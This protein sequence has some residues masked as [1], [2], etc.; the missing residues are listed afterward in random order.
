[1][2]IIFVN[3]NAFIHFGP[4]NF[5]IFIFRSKTYFGA[6]SSVPCCLPLG[7]EN[8]SKAMMH[9]E[10]HIGVDQSPKADWT[11]DGFSAKTEQEWDKL[12]RESSKQL[13]RNRPIGVAF[14]L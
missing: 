7:L 2:A 14:R 1:M 10:L 13:V 8:L 5:L 4:S 6:P 12:Y 11:F 9:Q 3:F